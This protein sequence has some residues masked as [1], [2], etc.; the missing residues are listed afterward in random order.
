MAVDVPTP[1]VLSLQPGIKSKE[2]EAL[3]LDLTSSL[4]AVLEGLAPE[5]WDA[6]TACDPWTV[7]DI[8]AH[9]LGWADALCSPRELA[10][11]A[12]GALA[13]R[14][15]LGN[16]VDAQ[17]H[18]QVE[19]GRNLGTEELVARLRQA[20]PRA[21]RFRRRVG[22]PLHYV[23]AYMSFLGGTIN[24]GY[25]MNVIFLRDLVVHKIDIC[26][27]V[28]RDAAL[29][30]ADGRVIADMLKDWARRS[31]ADA[32]IELTGPGGGIFLAGSGTAASIATDAPGM[33]RRLAGRPA[34]SEVRI[35]GD[36]T[37]AERWLATGCPV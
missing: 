19:R 11:Q 2:S 10:S 36:V 13:H 26:D 27:A 12:R 22:G 30:D 28:G 14:K 34:T 4:V 1:V 25:L 33:T 7:K 9:L 6:V 31:G 35:E 15:E 37:A 21:A 23:P 16:I 5:Q 32:R 3:A 24:V 17:N 29:G 18:V 20:M 8:A